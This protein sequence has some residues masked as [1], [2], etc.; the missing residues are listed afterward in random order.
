[1]RKT[2]FHRFRSNLVRGHLSP[3]ADFGILIERWLKK[4]RS[5]KGKYLRFVERFLFVKENG[6]QFI[7]KVKYEVHIRYKIESPSRPFPLVDKEKKKN[8][9]DTSQIGEE[10]KVIIHI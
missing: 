3:L 1:M 2:K 8:K 6:E 7:I 9:E 4:S 10:L 5:H